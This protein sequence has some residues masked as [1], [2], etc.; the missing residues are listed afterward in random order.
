[1]SYDF[2]GL[3]NDVAGRM[4]DVPLTSATFAT[5]GNHYIM[6]KEAVNLALREINQESFEWPF[7]HV[8][9]SD[10]LTA[11]TIRYSLPANVKTVDW[12]SFR[13]QRDA[14]FG[15]ETVSLAILS[16]DEYLHKFIDDEYSTSTD[17]RDVPKFI[18]RTPDQK[19]GVYPNPDNAYTLDYEY[20]VHPTDLVAA[21]DVPLVPE[22]FRHIITEGAMKQTYM[23][24]GDTQ[25]SIL[26]E[27]RFRK[28]IT[29]L[30]TIYTNR[31]DYVRS[32]FIERNRTY[33]N[34]VRTS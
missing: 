23:F 18:I 8:T 10:T 32:T 28:G 19:Y 16:Y 13:V 14:T 4:N 33:T 17:I 1:M 15:N 11:G 5:A 26:N 27:K 25:R 12:D 24:R 6:M 31:Y 2:L 9:Q 21:T 34:V 22:T 7:N 3:V 29:E 30:R 20:Y